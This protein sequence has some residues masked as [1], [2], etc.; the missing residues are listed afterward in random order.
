M[1]VAGVPS[2]LIGYIS[3]RRSGISFS[4]LTLA[5]AQ[6]FFALAYSV[7]APMTAGGSIP[8]P[9]LSGLTI[10]DGFD[11]ALGNWLFT[12]NVGCYLC[13]AIMLAAFYLSIRTFRAP[14]GM[15]PRAVKS[16][17][18]RLNSTGVN[19]KPYTLTAFV[20]SGMYA[21]LAAGLM[22]AMDPAGRGREDVLD[23]VRRGRADDDPPRLLPGGLIEGGQRIVRMF[24]RRRRRG[25]AGHDPEH[26]P[27]PKPLVGEWGDRP[28]AFSKSGTS[29]KPSAG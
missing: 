9:S 7:L 14:F 29:R 22:V 19:A 6:M 21:G 13:A 1:I 17:Q 15:M 26:H 11:L 2:V 8:A 10:R 27:A 28:W 3:F 16:N 4:I 23:L 18:Q 20:I 25:A 5:F 12:F 24:T